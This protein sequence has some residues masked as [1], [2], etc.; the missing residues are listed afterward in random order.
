MVEGN[1]ESDQ[2]L[3]SFGARELRCK[4][5][6][7]VFTSYYPLIHEHR[8]NIYLFHITWYHPC[9]TRYWDKDFSLK[10]SATLQSAIFR[11]LGFLHSQIDLFESFLLQKNQKKILF[12]SKDIGGKKTL[13]C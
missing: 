9:G 13:S 2:P 1:L 7:G 4:L 5:L 12:L 6:W 10:V 8:T 3:W 11:Y